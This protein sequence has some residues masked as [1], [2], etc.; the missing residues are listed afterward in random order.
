MGTE[1]REKIERAN[2]EE[3]EY[4]AQLKKEEA[5]K[6]QEEYENQARIRKE[7]R[8]AKEKADAAERRRI[9]K[10]KRLLEAEAA[11]KSGVSGVGALKIGQIAHPFIDPLIREAISGTGINPDRLIIE[12][13]DD[14]PDMITDVD[15]VASDVSGVGIYKHLSRVIPRAMLLGA[16]SKILR[17][18]KFDNNR[19][20]IRGLATKLV[21]H[22]SR[23]GDRKSFRGPDIDESSGGAFLTKSRCKGGA[24]TSMGIGVATNPSAGLDL[25]MK[26]IAE[27]GK[28]NPDID[29]R[30]ALKH[31]I[32]PKKDQ[33]KHKY[34]KLISKLQGG[35]MVVNPYNT[36]E[37]MEVPYNEHIMRG[38]H[39]IKCKFVSDSESDSES[40]DSD[41]PTIEDHV[42][43][44][45]K[46]GYSNPYGRSAYGRGLKKKRVLI[47]NRWRPMM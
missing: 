7:E 46:G 31:N 35:R 6:R 2:Q 12:M 36:A 19:N 43:V 11:K 32:P 45:R 16:N 39:A 5:E 47:T 23:L 41:Y 8:E 28:S 27:F 9:A 38:G 20:I 44:H 14:N 10:E 25:L 4:Q 3:R 17:A 22:F 33:Y 18:P 30:R 26:N 29:V 34:K 24:P 1:S 42:R 21:K 15:T 13:L 40:S 37:Y